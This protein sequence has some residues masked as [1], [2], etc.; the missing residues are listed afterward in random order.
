[1]TSLLDLP[2]E[3][4]LPIYEWSSNLHL[5]EVCQDIKTLFDAN[6]YKMVDNIL[7]PNV[8]QVNIS[9]LS[10]DVIK[11]VIDNQELMTDLVL[12]SIVPRQKI[13]NDI[14]RRQ[15]LVDWNHQYNFIN[16][17]FDGDLMNLYPNTLRSYWG[18]NMIIDD[19]NYYK[20]V[21]SQKKFKLDP[22]LKDYIEISFEKL[23]QANDLDS[24][25]KI[26]KTY[27]SVDNR[28]DKSK[29][30]KKLR[31]LCA[32]HNNF[33]LYQEIDKIPTTFTDMFPVWSFKYHEDELLHFI[34]HQNVGAIEYL[35]GHLETTDII[36]NSI[37]LHANLVFN[38][39]F[40]PNN[41]HLSRTIE[42]INWCIEY[43]NLEIFKKLILTPNIFSLLTT[44]VCM[45][46]TFHTVGY[47]YKKVVADPKKDT[48]NYFQSMSYIRAINKSCQ[49]NEQ[50]AEFMRSVLTKRKD[51][52]SIIKVAQEYTQSYI[53]K[54][55]PIQVQKK[56]AY[57]SMNKRYQN[58]IKY[59]CH[60]YQNRDTKQNK[61]LN[62][63]H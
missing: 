6:L 25:L 53:A 17:D 52:K 45:I 9:K 34:F 58:V 11:K 23:I 42:L 38:N 35:K 26:I 59:Q 48:K 20:P 36:T 12:R 47:S 32:F 62:Y 10:T 3:V 15:G 29:L 31:L 61:K 21:E 60:V 55:K 13:N 63:K 37:K 50:F 51:H 33:N 5:N 30:Y 40:G 39:Y 8:K 43:N 22:I 41:L 24:I 57:K 14:W 16:P 56:K 49:C 19:K 2:L 1:M 28:L 27:E 44:N 7:I 46:A 18:S 4:Q 54:N